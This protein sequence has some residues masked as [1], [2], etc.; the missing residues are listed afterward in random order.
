[1]ILRDWR[2]ADAALLRGCY[3]RERRSW[4]DDLG[5]DTEW[6]WATIEHARVAWGLP[7]LLAVDDAGEVRG[8]AFYMR[9]G[10]TLHI[11][12]LV[13]SSAAVTDQLLDGVLGS[14]PP[15]AA[16]F[17]R[18]RAPGLVDALHRG[19]L[20]PERFLYLSRPLTAADA[21]LLPATPHRAV[22]SDS[23]NQGDVAAAARLFHEA[24]PRKAAQHFAGDGTLD[25]W[26]KYVAGVVAQGGCGQLDPDATRV[27]RL[28]DEL[29]GI[30][31]V[32]VIAPDTAHLAQL[33]VHPGHRG[34]GIASALLRDVLARGASSG[35]SAMTLLVSEQNRPARQVYEGAGF[36]PRGLFVAGRHVELSMRQ[37]VGEAP[38]VSPQAEYQY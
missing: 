34:Q 13:A 38:V 30:A 1:M 17:I 9:E 27:I 32:T 18:D 31:M 3:E 23:W 5:W 4:R 6:T 22:V 25:D 14:A 21:S 35:K 10:E 2:Q 16:C 37:S 28:G 8:W 36:V 29:T 15:R 20:D 26:T 12:G 19:G 11:G 24:Y 33:V 7:G